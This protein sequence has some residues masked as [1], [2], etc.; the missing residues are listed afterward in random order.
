M[1]NGFSGTSDIDAL[2]ASMLMGIGRHVGFADAGLALAAEFA[3]IGC[4]S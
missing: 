1:A 3:E 2:A 4:P